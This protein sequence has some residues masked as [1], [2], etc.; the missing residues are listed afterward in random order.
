MRI[1]EDILV[2]IIMAMFFIALMIIVFLYKDF[3]VYNKLNTVVYNFEQEVEVTGYLTDEIYDDFLRKLTHCG[4]LFEVSLNHKKPLEY[5]LDEPDE[6][7][8]T[9]E[10]LYLE[11][12]TDYILDTIYDR[13]KT[14]SIYRMDSGDYIQVLVQQVDKTGMDLARSFLNIPSKGGRLFCT[15]GGMIKNGVK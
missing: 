8:N 2:P 3:L 11:T 14:E 4:G 1:I 6:D 9:S 10:T 15:Y 12:G 7:G 5:P 13:D